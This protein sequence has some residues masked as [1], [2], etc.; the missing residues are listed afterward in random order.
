MHKLAFAALIVT[1]TLVVIV[2]AFWTTRLIAANHVSSPPTALPNSAIGGFPL[3]GTLAPDFQLT[4]QFG[5]PLRLSSLRGQEIVLSFIDARCKTI[6]PLTA[7][8]MYNARTQL[9]ASAARQVQL[10]AVNANPDATGLTEVQSWSISHGMLHQWL[11]LT[12]TAQ[13]LQAVYHLY[14]VYDQIDAS[15]QAV[16]D[17]ILFII[18]ASGHERLYFETLDSQRPADLSDEVAGLV[19]GMRQ[20]LPKA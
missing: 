7:Q 18:D 10:V 3:S 9:G 15:G 14:N 1:S 6:C 20:W 17:P 2:A 16:H 11:F 8:I 13:Q 4:D 19:D 12:G 5:H